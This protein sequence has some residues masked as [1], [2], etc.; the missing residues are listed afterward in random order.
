MRGLPLLVTAG[1]SVIGTSLSIFIRAQ[2]RHYKAKKLAQL[3]EDYHFGNNDRL[4]DYQKAKRYYEQAL[5]LDS[6]L[7]STYY[8]LGNLYH[9]GLGIPADAVQARVCYEKSLSLNYTAAAFSLGELSENAEASFQSAQYYELNHQGKATE[10]KLVFDG[11]LKAAQAGHS[12][13]KVF[14]KRLNVD[15]DSDRINELMEFS[16]FKN[17]AKYHSKQANQ[18]ITESGNLKPRPLN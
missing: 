8:H 5:S 17:R 9:Y 12:K 1:A 10:Q 16:Y 11:Y 2:F 13:S 18:V 6:S 3:G 15:T 14:L 4:Q 7:A